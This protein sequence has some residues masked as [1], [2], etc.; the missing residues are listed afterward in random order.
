M[1]WRAR[2]SK[3]ASA[4]KV[5]AKLLKEMP[6]RPVRITQTLL[7]KKIDRYIDNQLDKMPQTWKVL[8]KVVETRLQFDLRRLRWAADSF[9]EENVSPSR[10]ALLQRASIG[11][12]IWEV[13]AVKTATDAALRALRR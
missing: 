3:T 13:P 12:D 10:S 5:A 8:D 9:R 1:E 6:G 4:I 7:A 11:S 2:D